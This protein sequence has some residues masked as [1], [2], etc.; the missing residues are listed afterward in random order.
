MRLIPP[1]AMPAWV[2]GLKVITSRCESCHR[3]L[4]LRH[5]SAR[6]AG[7]RMHGSWYC[8]SRCFQSAAEQEVLRLLKPGTE[9]AA[10]VERMPLGLSLISHGFLTIEQLKKAT[11]ELKEGGGEIGELLVRQGS[12]SEKQ[13]TAALAKD[14]GCPVFAVPKHA[15]PIGIHLPSTLMHRYFM[16]PVHYVVST[17][18]LLVGFAH[19]IE[20]GLLYA[21]E[22][23]TG[24][25]TKPCFVTP[26]DFQRQMQ[27]QEKEQEPPGHTPV[28]EMTFEG[29]QT[30]GEIARTLC[31]SGVEIEAEEALIERCKEYLWARLKSETQAV[32]ILFRT[33]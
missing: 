19:S 5:L 26:V 1:I 9:P 22:Q 8:S 15:S 25:E 23:I 21:I 14:W 6:K 27:Q 31:T 20:Y 12:V 32:D 10:R 33:G 4:A 30:A 28:R 29:I 13:V 24:C 2:A 16:V 7:I 3:L 17:N 18:L 11:D